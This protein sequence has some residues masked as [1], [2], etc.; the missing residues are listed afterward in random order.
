M[1]K[2]KKQ[3][4][5]LKKQKKQR[6]QQKKRVKAGQ[7][8]RTRGFSRPMGPAN[9]G[10]YVGSGRIGLSG[11]RNYATTRR[12]QVIEEDEYIGEVNGSVGFV[13]T[14][15][16]VN[17]GNATTF[18]WGNR[19][20]QLYEEYDYEYLEFYIK[21]E[22]SEFAT[23][24]QVGKVMLSFDF[25]ASDAAPTTKQQVEDTI[26][27]SDGM[28]CE[29]IRL[30]VD[31][32]CLRGSLQKHYVRPGAQPANTDLKMYDVGNLNV[33]TQGCTNTT[34]IGE[35]HVRYRVRLSEPVLEPALV[36][37]GL[38]HFSSIAATTA[39]NFAGAVLQSGG[40]PSLTGI[41][42]GVNTIVFP[43]GIPAN[44]FI[45]M[46]VAGA[47]SATL[48]GGFTG[49]TGLNILS[50]SAVRDAASA[51]GSASGTTVFPAMSLTTMTVPTAGITFTLST[52]STITGTGTM[53]LF[54]IS[55]PASVLT[56]VKPSIERENELASRLASLER[57]IFGRKERKTLTFTS[58]EEEDASTYVEDGALRLRGNENLKPPVLGVSTSS[59][60]AST[61]SSSM[62]EVI[63][64]YVARKS[65]SNK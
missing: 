5:Q 62:L 22:V 65:S 42:L 1:Q 24:G 12:S 45:F 8:R 31:P 33:S 17:P 4:K 10:G 15:F 20:A 36:V 23:N 47:T 41:T 56:V 58:D 34:V 37:G 9:N 64:E 39:N 60:P 40:T 52:V 50:Q 21:R 13:C 53:D 48:I 38:V 54:I 16:P 49:G 18:P 46:A 26:P 57:F 59:P 63:G 3:K 6:P 61:L 30:P 19:I 11:S 25:D 7:G 14:Q 27:H 35:L 29:N 51:Y 32:K 43:A 2:Q 44:Y 55:M 28:P